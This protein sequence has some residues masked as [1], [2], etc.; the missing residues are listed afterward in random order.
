MKMFDQQLLL[1]GVGFG[2]IDENG[3]THWLHEMDYDSR[4]V[5]IIVTDD[6]V[7]A[8][9]RMRQ[10][11]LAATPAARAPADVTPP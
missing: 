10:D 4:D 2:W 8:V 3:W 9:Q 1:G 5:S 6:C 11:V 7:A